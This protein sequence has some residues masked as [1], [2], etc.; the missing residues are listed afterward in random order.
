M[1]NKVLIFDIWAELAHFRKPFTTTSPLTYSIPPRTAITGILGAIIGLDKGKN[2]NIFNISSSNV[3]IKI[4]NPIKKTRKNINYINT[5]DLKE[6][7]ITKGR[8]QIKLELLCNPKYRLFVNHKES[9]IYNCLK[10]NLNQHKSFY[11]VSLGLSENIANYEYLGEF[12][13]RTID[14]ENDWKEIDSV[15][16]LTIHKN[17]NLAKTDM[18]DLKNGEYF[19]ENIP[20]EMSEDR[21]VKE[22]YE[23]LFERN[24]KK[25]KTKYPQYILIEDLNE[26]ILWL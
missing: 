20:G 8:T 24:G 18:F 19:T 10:S 9:E 2:N 1:D 4:L 3:A 14:D 11:T 7:R 25:L 16:N 21:E 23:V 17:S 5:K 26:K 15:Y 12:S 6:F 13:Y 22:Y